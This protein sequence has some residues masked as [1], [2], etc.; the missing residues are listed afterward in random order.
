MRNSKLNSSFLFFEKMRLFLFVCLF[1]SC[2]FLHAQNE[3]IYIWSGAVTAN[4]IKVNAKLTT[5]SSTIRLVVDE[6][7]DFSS[8]HFS[9]YYSVDSTTNFMVSMDIN[10][11]IELTLYYYC[12]ESGGIMDTSANDIGEFR[13]ISNTSFSYKFAVGSCAL[14]SDHKVYEVMDSLNPDFYLITGDLHY[15]NPNSATD[16]NVHRLPYET[17]VLS[18]PKAAQFFKSLPIAYIWDDHDFSGN[19]VDSNA[20]GKFNAR[21]AYHEYVPHY[22]LGLGTG[23]NYPIAQAF[24]IGRVRFIMTDL[25]SMRSPS[26]MLG[27]DQTSWFENE[28]L[29]AKNNNQII[30]WVSTVSWNGTGTDNWGAYTMERFQISDFLNFSGIENLFILSGDAHMLAIDDG[31]NANFS[32]SI[33]PFQYPIFQ[34]AALNQNGSYKGGTFNQGGYFPN[35]LYTYGQFGIVNVT[36]NGGD[37]ICI[38]FTGYRVDS[39]GTTIQILNNYNFCRLLPTASIDEQITNENFIICPNPS[40]RLVIRFEKKKNVKFIRIYSLQGQ[41]LFEESK[42]IITNELN[43]FNLDYLPQSQYIIEVETENQIYKKYWIKN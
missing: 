43:S 30:A 23:A 14:D 40:N 34:A 7:A 15:A 39:L 25:R 28:C 17:E 19:D 6:E 42:S 27:N 31:T 8:P 5:S 29:N 4:S 18:K 32:S 24:T 21:I 3:V 35:P 22:P 37:S 12:V 26:S 36:D 41:L 2:I 1:F 9:S 16:I 38:A 33:T 10:G 20:A 11:L 13:T